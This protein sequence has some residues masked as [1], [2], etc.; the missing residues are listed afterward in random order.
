MHFFVIYATLSLLTTS[1]FAVPVGSHGTLV[2]TPRDGTTTGVLQDP[3]TGREL[4][5]GK[6]KDGLINISYDKATAPGY[7]TKSIAI[8]MNTVDSTFVLATNLRSNPDNADNP[9]IFNDYTVPKGIWDYVPVGE[10]VKGFI[11]ITE[12]Q[13]PREGYNGENIYPPATEIILTNRKS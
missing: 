7:V 2:L 13:E 1:A 6:A 12:T 8:N 4:V 11:Q 5:R 9:Y 3:R 10:S